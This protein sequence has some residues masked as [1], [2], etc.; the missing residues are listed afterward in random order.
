MSLHNQ[1]FGAKAGH[2]KARFRRREEE[3]WTRLRGRQPS[4][5][6]TESSVVGLI[7]RLEIDTHPVARSI[8]ILGSRAGVRKSGSAGPMTG[9][10]TMNLIDGEKVATSVA[11]P[12]SLRGKR[13]SST[14]ELPPLP[15][16]VMCG[17][18]P[19]PIIPGAGRPFSQGVFFISQLLQ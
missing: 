15:G 10:A 5:P 19:H 9:F 2:S 12:V 8:A 17:A 18:Q 4:T 11:A 14:R 7:R 3:C 13:A 1:P 6:R 16:R